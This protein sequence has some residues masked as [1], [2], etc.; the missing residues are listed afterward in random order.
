MVRENLALGT[1]IETGGMVKQKGSVMARV[2][3]GE[4]GTPFVPASDAPGDVFFRLGVM[5]STGNSVEPDRIAAHKWFN[6]AAHKGND[7]ALDYRSELA[8]EMSR[9]EIAEAQRQAREW[10]QLH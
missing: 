9:D 5:Y 8:A 10:M 4:M 3:F 6:L 7:Q 2:D 1:G